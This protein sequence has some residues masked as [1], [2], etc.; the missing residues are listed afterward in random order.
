MPRTEFPIKLFFVR[1]YVVLIR[2]AFEPLVAI[3]T[4]S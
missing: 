1:I 3:T 2:P 4:V